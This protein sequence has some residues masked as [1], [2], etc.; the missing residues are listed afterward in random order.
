MTLPKEPLLH[1]LV[2]GILLFV[3]FDLLP[4]KPEDD[5]RF[6][7]VGDEQLLLS[8]M[9][10]KPQLGPEGA[11]E[12][13][14]SLGAEQRNEWVENYIHEE[15]M[16]QEALALGLDKNNYAAR[17]RL[18]TQLE[19]INQGFIRESLII[20]DEELRVHYADNRDLYFKPPQITF[21]HVYLADGQSE[22]EQIRLL[23]EQELLY[24]NETSVPFYLSGSRGDHFLYHRN[25]VNKEQPEVGSHFGD[26]FASDVFALSA[27]KSGWQGPFRSAY[28][29]H[30]VLIS[31]RKA[32]YYPLLDE[33]RVRLKDHVTR[34]RIQRELDEFYKQIRSTYSISIIDPTGSS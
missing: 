31:N 18:I 32:G 1:F 2:A 16:Y 12:Y 14:A 27:D 30:L 13:L 29:Y 23:A 9:N 4:Q 26:G 6:I 15:V 21:T 10:R 34:L 28:G 22:D 8:I 17:R 33:I 11:S 3:L 5:A 19:Y 24:L 7:Q 25:Y 20:S